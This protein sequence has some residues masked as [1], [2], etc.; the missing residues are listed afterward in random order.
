MSSML[1]KSSLMLLQRC[2]FNQ[3]FLIFILCNH[4]FSFNDDVFHLLLSTIVFFVVTLQTEN[5]ILQV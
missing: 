5:V 3:I 1:V 2:K 4:L